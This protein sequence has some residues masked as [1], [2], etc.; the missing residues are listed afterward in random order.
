MISPTSRPVRSAFP[1]IQ[2]ALD[3]AIIAMSYLA[4]LYWQTASIAAP[5]LQN[6]FLAALGYVVAGEFFGI[7]N[8]SHHRPADYDILL[9]SAAWMTGF[10]FAVFGGF[11][12]SPTTEPLQSSQQ[13]L[14]FILALLCILSSWETTHLDI[15]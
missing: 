4:I 9:I 7:F 6:V 11:L 13:V 15:N 2:I 12:L 1:A 3:F 5:S 10:G 8:T 14:W